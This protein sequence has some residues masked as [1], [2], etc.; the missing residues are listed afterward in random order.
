MIEQ[1]GLMG[2]EKLSGR[3]QSP[4]KLEK[5]QV[6]FDNSKRLLFI[7]KLYSLNFFFRKNN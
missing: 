3:I 7:S 5:L 4:P 6:Y 1:V 2:F